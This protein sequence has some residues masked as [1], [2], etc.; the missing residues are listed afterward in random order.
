M[1]IQKLKDQYPEGTRIEVIHMEDT[2]AVKKGS[3]GTVQF[4]DDMGTIHVSWDDG[5]SLGLIPGVD[6]FKVVQENKLNYEV[7]SVD[8]KLNASL[9]RKDYL[10]PEPH[11]IRKA[12]KVTQK[13]YHNLLENPLDDKE[14]IAA[15]ADGMYQD[16]D[17]H[18]SIVVYCDE[19]PD[20]ILVQSEGYNYARYSSFIPNIHELLETHTLEQ[21]TDTKYEK[22][23]VLVVEPNNKPFVAIIDN[24]LKASQA[25]VGGYIEA[26]P[27]SDT[28][29]MIANEEGKILD[30][31]AN[32]RLGNDVIAGRFIIVGV[33]EGEH[34]KSLSQQDIK[35]YTDQFQEIEMID[36][37]EVQKN[38]KFEI[39]F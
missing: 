7:R 25:M 27:L 28:A 12:V 14:Y 19:E 32:R 21:D 35:K 13:E 31:P 2:Q 5:G 33:D 3:L 8:I 11:Y 29:E 15:L 30:L 39:I 6:S 37:S 4:V 24:D 18:F 9:I 20:A 1:K 34:F 17:V 36:Q 23:K 16:D 10:E 22:I 38:M 26:I